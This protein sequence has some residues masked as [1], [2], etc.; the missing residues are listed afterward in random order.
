M[1]GQR[2][3]LNE[4]GDGEVDENFWAQ[5]AADQAA[6]RA[7][8]DGEEGGVSY[9]VIQQACLSDSRLSLILAG[10][11][12]SI[13]FN[14]QFFH[15]DDDDGPGFDDGF[16]GD[17]AGTADPGEQD[18]LA[19]TQG[20]TRRVRPEFIKYTK[21]AKR[22]DVRKLKDNIWKGLKIPTPDQQQSADQ[23]EMVRDA[24]FACGLSKAHFFFCFGRRLTRT[25][26]VLQAPRKRGRSMK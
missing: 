19:E 6:G 26:W 15:D 7:T 8:S 9:H 1:R 11:G 4:N 10:D 23:E 17:L 16:D 24:R 12:S 25:R 3:P 22:V 18:L 2:N 20:R 14:T 13:P 5:A 21:R